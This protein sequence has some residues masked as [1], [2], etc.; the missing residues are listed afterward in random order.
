MER[1]EAARKDVRRQALPIRNAT[2]HKA[3]E[4]GY[5]QLSIFK[6]GVSQTVQEVR[7]FNHHPQRNFGA[8]VVRAARRREVLAP[9]VGA[10]SV[11]RQA[12]LATNIR[13]LRRNTASPS[14][15]HHR[16]NR[17]LDPKP[18]RHNHSRHSRLIR[19]SG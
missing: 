15:R 3:C 14:G 16:P 11:P 5:G 6:S 2:F 18:D 17:K 10:R 7:A 1:R 4:D 9:A 8:R 12:V 19:R 13:D